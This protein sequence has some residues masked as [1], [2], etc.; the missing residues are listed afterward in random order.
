[1]YVNAPYIYSKITLNES[2]TID[3]NKHGKVHKKD[4]WYTSFSKESMII[5]W[6][7]FGIL[8]GMLAINILI[9][10][11]KNRKKIKGYNILF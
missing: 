9:T 1:M 11:G 5:D 7:E 4:T 3:Y 2:I 6:I 10:I 8:L